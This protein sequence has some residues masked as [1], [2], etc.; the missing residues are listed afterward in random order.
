MIGPLLRSGTLAGFHPLGAVGHPVYLAASQLRA[1]IGRRLGADLADTFAIPQRNEDGDTVDWYAPRPGTVVPWSSATGDERAEAQDRLLETRRQIEALA[2]AMAAETDSER[3]IF[4]RLLGYVTSFP[5]EEHIYLVDGRPVLT[6]WG[7]VR[8]EAAVGSDPLVNL[9]LHAAPPVSALGDAKATRPRIPWWVWLLA[10]LAILAAGLFFLR[11]CQPP[12]VRIPAWQPDAVA[13]AQGPDTE[14][15][16]Q[17]PA[18]PGAVPPDSSGVVSTERRVVDRRVIERGGERR[19]LTGGDAVPGQAT[20]VEGAAGLSEGAV[21]PV[22]D[23]QVTDPM[24]TEVLTADGSSEPIGA[25]G[26]QQVGDEPAGDAAEFPMGGPPDAQSDIPEAGEV[27]EPLG[28][29]GDEVQEPAGDAGPPGVEPGTEPGTAPVPE[30]E[31]EPV[32]EPGTEQEPTPKPAPDAETGRPA[33]PDTQADPQ[34][35]GQPA[36]AASAS[37]QAGTPPTP[38]EGPP[39]PTTGKPGDGGAAAKAPGAEE[40]A[41]KG[42]KSD[43]AKA[44][45]TPQPRA[46]AP[47]GAARP[48]APRRWLSSGWHT[49]TALQDPKT[50]LPVQMEYQLK[51]G[52]GRVRLKRHDGSICENGASAVLEGGKLVIDSSG[53]IVC[54]DGTNFGKPRVECQPGPDGKPNC[55]GRYADDKPFGIDMREQGP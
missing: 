6:F 49:A 48:P 23:V 51:D 35:E 16:P 54:A 7:F 42:A 17:D 28:S 52:A 9:D 27:P 1:A 18:E 15:L 4:G 19:V 31:P 30:P 44:G 20:T 55:T 41:G 21:S 47:V 34:A 29:V 45:K 36:D 46:S 25:V 2:Q 11:A 5:H 24:A 26:D 13:P 12:S 10:L 8:D 40:G 39:E 22:G 37:D 33:P 3:Q 53:N 14:V 50:G 38:P 32:I 43:P